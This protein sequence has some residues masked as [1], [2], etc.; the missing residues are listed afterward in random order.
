MSSQPQSGLSLLAVPGLLI[1]ELWAYRGFIWASVQR[2]WRARYLGSQL[3]LGWAIIHPFALILLYTL[4][5]A[6][7]MH[8]A[9]VGHSGPFAYSIY[10]CA[11]LLTWNLFSELLGRSVGIFISNAAL[12]KK[13]SF[14]KLSLPMIAVLSSLLHYAITLGLFL[15]F[16]LLIGQFPGWALL[17]AVPVVLTLIML[18]L[19]LGLLAGL[20][21]VFYRDVE[22]LVTLVL[23][24]WFWLTP[25]V[26][27]QTILPD[28]L[29]ALLALN[30]LQPIIQAMQSIL[31]DGQLP[32]PLNLVYPVALALCLLALGLRV[33][34]RLGPELVD[35]L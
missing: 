8:P 34:Q 21:N 7:L 25:I 10:L 4:V 29:R 24:F 18:T 15:G 11:G 5:F 17:A 32:N 1:R 2:E 14:P 23:Q 20:I 9:L 13:L 33:Y 16:L 6:R 12:L 30:P 3:G 35:E 31:L 22:Q 19:G 26:Y 27:V 28:W